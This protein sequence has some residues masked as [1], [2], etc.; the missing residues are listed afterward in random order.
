MDKEA[1]IGLLLEQLDESCPAGFAVAL[2]IKFASPRYLFQ[3]YRRDWIDY[4]SKH[5]LVLRDPTVR[6][7]FEHTGTIRWSALDG[8]D[9]TDVM[10]KA[11]EYGLAYGFT[12]AQEDGQSRSVASFARSDREFT[13]AEMQSIATILTR[14]HEETRAAET[15]SPEDHA[16][17]KRLSILLTHA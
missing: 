9:A 4:Y 3:A 7:G 13:E 15:L 16:A 1:S 14:L 12:A 2:H 11:A 17:L 8:Q 6:W 5:A 10:E